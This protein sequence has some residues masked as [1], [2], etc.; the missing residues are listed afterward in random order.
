MNFK[1][2]FFRGVVK[3]KKVIIV[4]FFLCT[5]ISGFCKQFVGVNY[6]MN[7]YLPEDTAST[8]S[9]D[10]MEEEFGSGIPNARVMIS[11][12]SIPEALELKDKISSI[13]GVSDV[14]WL[15]GVSIK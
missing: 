5:L 2:K 11:N 13:Y 8:I 10:V 14:I 12:V 3:H 6:D 15:D 9:L 1:E 7:S 4:I